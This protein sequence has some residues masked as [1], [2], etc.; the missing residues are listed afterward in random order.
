MR[1]DHVEGGCELVAVDIVRRAE[2]DDVGIVTSASV[3]RPALNGCD[4]LLG[5]HHG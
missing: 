5:K 3:D 1:G 2:E 4:D